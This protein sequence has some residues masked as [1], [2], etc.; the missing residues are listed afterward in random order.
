MT[1]IKQKATVHQGK[2]ELLVR[3]LRDG[4]TVEIE[5]VIH[6][7]EDKANTFGSFVQAAIDAKTGRAS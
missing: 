1:A 2:V 3:E 5:A 6:E 7:S 4:S